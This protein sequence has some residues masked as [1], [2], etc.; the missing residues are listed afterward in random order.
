MPHSAI[1]QLDVC[2]LGTHITHNRM[3]RLNILFPI[4]T[5]QTKIEEHITLCELEFENLE[6]P[7]PEESAP[8]MEHPTIVRELSFKIRGPLLH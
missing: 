5:E 4:Q 8:G 2:I 7:D 1:L 3:E 6:N